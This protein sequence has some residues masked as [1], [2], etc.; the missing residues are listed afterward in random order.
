MFFC[1]Y[2]GILNGGFGWGLPALFA[3]SQPVLITI[4]AALLNRHIPSARIWASLWSASLELSGLF[5]P[6]AICQMGALLG[7]I[8][9]FAAAVSLSLG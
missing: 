1:S 3:A 7:A 4:V 6:K 9:D 8:L 5:L 2:C